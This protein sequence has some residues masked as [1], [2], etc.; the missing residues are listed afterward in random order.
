MYSDCDRNTKV[1][2]EELINLFS[3]S[4]TQICPIFRTLSIHMTLKVV[5]ATLSLSTKSPTDLQE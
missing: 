4:L 3:Q 1:R 2:R 5:E